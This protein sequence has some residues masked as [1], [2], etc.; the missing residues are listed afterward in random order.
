MGE[1][2]LDKYAPVRNGSEG[3]L[4]KI[5]LAE[6]D[7]T[8]AEGL[9]YSLEAEGYEVVL[10]GSVREGREALAQEPVSLWACRTGAASSS[11]V[12]PRRTAAFR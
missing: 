12:P 9:Q 10:C 4:M 8:I 1:I 6:D 5:L 3:V 11:A 7:R 2:P